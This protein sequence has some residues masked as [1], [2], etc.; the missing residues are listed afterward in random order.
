MAALLRASLVFPSERDV[1]LK[2]EGSRFYGVLPY[3]ISRNLVEIPYQLLFPMLTSLILYWMVGQASTFGQFMLYYL[4]SVL[5]A[6]VGSSLGLLIGSIS[7]D[8][9]TGTALISIIAIPM[10]MFSG[11]FKNRENYPVWIGWLEYLSPFKY[12]LASGLLNEVSA[13]S[14]RV[15]ELNFD[16]SIWGNIGV[17]IALCLGFRLL[18]LFFLWWLRKKLE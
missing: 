12:G 8:E 5:M 17:L 7:K 9:K 3:F 14:S 6:F 10:L 4:I 15:S 18:A 2:E 16:L 11:V 1:F 13:K